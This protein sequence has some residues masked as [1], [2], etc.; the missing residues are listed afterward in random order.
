MHSAVER[1][2]ADGA[3]A[4]TFP[5]FRPRAAQQAMADAVEAWLADGGVLV[6]ESGTG[7]GKTL[8]YLVPAL[9]SGRRVLISTG[10]RHLQDQL[11]H[12]DLPMVRQALGSDVRTELLKG[13]ANY[14]CLERL[15]DRADASQWLGARERGELERVALWAATTRS[16]DIAE[17]ADVAE[18]SPVW[19]LVTSTRDN[20]L[21]SE[22]RHYSRCHVM[23]ARRRALQA[24]VLVVNHHLFFADLALRD[25]GLGAVLPGVD[26]LIFDEAH[27]LEETATAFLGVT[28]TSGQ[29][30]ELLRDVITAERRERSGI[31]GLEA[32]VGIVRTA[33]ASVRECLPGRPTRLGWTEAH[34]AGT[35]ASALESLDTALSDLAERLEAVAEVGLHLGRVAGRAGILRERLREISGR[36]SHEVVRWVEVLERSYRLSATPLDVSHVLR[37]C[38]EDDAKAWMFTSATLSVGGDFSHFTTALGIEP[39]RTECWP[40]PFD[41]ATQSLLYLP[42]GLP[43]PRASSDY[44]ARMIACIRPVLAASRGR[45]FVLFTSHRALQEAARAFAGT[46]DFPLFVQGSASRGELLARFRSAGNGVLLG[47]GSFWEGVD[48][49]GEALSCVIID[50]LP[51]ASPEDPLVRARLRAMEE[52]GG[53][54]FR[55]YQLPRAVIAL[56]QGAGRLIRDPDDRG[57]L[58]LCDP[59]LLTRPYGRLFLGSLPPMPRTR[60]LADV[61]AHFASRPSWN[62]SGA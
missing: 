34:A 21:G 59:R 17:V 11:F 50:R 32:S 24:D 39:T 25:E 48:V 58:V 15:A 62:G 2:A 46:L 56:R 7:T 43:D 30:V 60:D 57:V 19:P 18:D 40:S 28:V 29:V 38:I 54:P 6:A 5:G 16:G 61:E 27:L 8:A 37:G 52:A 35:L 20:C 47:T 41:Y 49:R 42:E 12:R 1:L 4:R 23:E 45:A 13:R 33:L 10:T 53:N 51:F 14:L 26:A 44:T 36:E 31:E 9:T 3:I 55:D 22:C